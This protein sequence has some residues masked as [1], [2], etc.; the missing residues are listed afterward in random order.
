MAGDKF[1]AWAHPAC[2]IKFATEEFTFDKLSESVHITNVT[3]QK[4]YTRSK[5]NPNLP[6]DNAWTSD[7]LIK[8]FRSQNV[9]GKT[10][11]PSAA[12]GDDEETYV[13]THMEMTMG[14][15]SNRISKS[16]EGSTSEDE[17]SED[18]EEMESE[19]DDEVTAEEKETDSEE[20][21]TDTK[22][23]MGEKKAASTTS[24]S[25]PCLFKHVIYPAIKKC[26]T[27]IAELSYDQIEKKNGRFELF[28]CDWLITENHQVC[29][30]EINRSPSMEYYTPKH[31][32][33]LDE[34]LSDLVKG[35]YLYVRFISIFFIFSTPSS[36]LFTS[37][38][39]TSFEFREP[40]NLPIPCY[41]LESDICCYCVI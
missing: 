9:S 34:L 23:A 14:R 41:L 15:S 11:M 18:E 20:E 17:K 33:V 2:T 36:F 4:R 21:E 32:G 29:L 35:S 24:K 7:D 25:D 31:V 12:M 38:F 39:L 1:Q 5:P 19:N 40:M 30:L 22:R 6:E 26:L 16:S 27:C 28:G 8:Y 37:S 10:F 13:A 3:V